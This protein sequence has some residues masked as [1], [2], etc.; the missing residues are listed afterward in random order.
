MQT[1][2][3]KV[4]TAFILSIIANSVVDMFALS[5]VFYYRVTSYITSNWF[6]LFFL[7]PLFAA[8]IVLGAI[9]QYTIREVRGVTGKYKAFYV[10]SRVLSLV[11]I[12]EGSIILTVG[13]VYLGV[14]LIFF[15]PYMIVV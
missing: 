2:E 6:A 5:I 10:I 15:I 12:I 1:K 7:A 9:A 11:A 8:P 13:L 3:Q 4:Q 14:G